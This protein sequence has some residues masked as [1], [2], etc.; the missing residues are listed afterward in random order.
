M[1]VWAFRENSSVLPR[2]EAAS[3]AFLTQSP[4][5]EK[6]SSNSEGSYQG[7]ESAGGA[8][9][10]SLGWGEGRGAGHRYHTHSCRGFVGSRNA[11]AVPPEKK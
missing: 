11:A 10:P 4:R 5:R 2:S 8:I 7:S 1:G 3:S 9:T 6:I